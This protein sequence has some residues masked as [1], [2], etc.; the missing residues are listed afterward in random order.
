MNT[1]ETIKSH[2]IAAGLTVRGAAEATGLTPFTIQR[3]ESQD[4]NP[5][6]ETLRALAEAYRL[7]SRQISA[8]VKDQTN[9]ER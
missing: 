5:T 6:L 9:T 7:S 8:L 4:S 2:R 1:G 3:T